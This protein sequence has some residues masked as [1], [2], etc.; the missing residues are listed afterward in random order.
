VATNGFAVPP[1]GVEQASS[2]TVVIGGQALGVFDSYS[3]GEP[4]A[5]DN[6]HRP[7]GMG[8]EVSYGSLPSW[9]DISV[10]RVYQWD[11]DWELERDLVP[12]AGRVS[13]SMTEQPLDPDG[14]AYGNPKTW[15]GRFLSI[16]P[17]KADSTS[18]AVRMWEIDA[19]ITSQA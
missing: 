9:S 4:A 11:R 3:G 14:N 17:G 15:S 13:F 5:K 16:K 12:L 1:G 18:D 8:A 7:G 2:I 6:K 19:E 10:S